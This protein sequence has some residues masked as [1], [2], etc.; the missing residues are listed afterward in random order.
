M[1]K[2]WVKIADNQIRHVWND[3]EGNEVYISPDWYQCNGT[4]MTEHGEDMEYSHTEI[5]VMEE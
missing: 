1:K 4:P 2:T 3:E 5:L